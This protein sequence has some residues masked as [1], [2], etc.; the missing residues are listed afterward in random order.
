MLQ[1]DL[2]MSGY[3]TVVPAEQRAFVA[4]GTAGGATLAGRWRIAAAKTALSKTFNGGGRRKVA[5]VC[6]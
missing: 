5:Q 1:N 4:S 2:T 3:F 6:R